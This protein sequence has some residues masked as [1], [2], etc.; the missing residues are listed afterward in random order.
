MRATIYFVSKFTVIH[1]F[2]FRIQGLGRWLSDDGSANMRTQ[3][4]I[5]STHIIAG[6]GYMRL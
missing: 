3:I 6:H 4:G 5:P 1:N 2:I